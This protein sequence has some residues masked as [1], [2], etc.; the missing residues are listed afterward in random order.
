MSAA[1]SPEPRAR[2]LQRGRAHRVELRRDPRDPRADKLAVRG[3]LRGRREPR[4]HPRDPRTG[5][6]PL[7]PSVDLKVIL[8]EENQGRG[9]TVTDGFRA[10]RGGEMAGYLDVD[11]EVHCALRALA[12]AGDRARRRRR[13]RAAHLRAS[14]CARSTATS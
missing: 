9:A 13:H 12:R 1:P 5:S 10:A 4:P 3:H 11:L 6:W 2:L 8:H 14:R 7:T